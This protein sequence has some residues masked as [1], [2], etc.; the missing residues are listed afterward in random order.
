VTVLDN[1]STDEAAGELEAALPP[2]VKFLRA[3]DNTGYAGGMNQLLH[4]WLESATDDACCILLAHDVILETNALQQLLTAAEHH[5]QF[6]ILGPM[7]RYG[8]GGQRWSIG[9]VWGRWR[10]LHDLQVSGV[11][12]IPGHIEVREVDWINGATLLLRASCLRAIGLFNADLFAYWEDVELCLRAR[13]HA[14]KVGI[15]PTARTTITDR[16]ASS[17][18]AAYYGVRNELEVARIHGGLPAVFAALARSAARIPRPIAGAVAPWR[19]AQRRT[20]SKEFGYA[21]VEGIFD[22]GRRRLGKRHSAPGR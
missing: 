4:A 2:V 10:G 12:E 8:I 3:A 5:P 21:I 1:Q 18:L 9:A 7:V 13:R 16:A 11:D 14:W 6:G 17:E 19:A 22:F 15:V 20:D